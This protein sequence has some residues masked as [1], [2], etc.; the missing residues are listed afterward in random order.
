MNLHLLDGSGFMHRAFHAWPKLSRKD[1]QPCGA[2]LGFCELLWGML[3]RPKHE[4]THLAAIMDGGHSGR[5]KLYKDYKAHRPARDPAL[6]AQYPFIDRACVAF[7]VPVLR[8][9]GFEADDVIATLSAQCT[10]AGGRT[11]IHTADKDLMQ[12]VDERVSIY[13]PTKKLDIGRDQVIA[14]W[15]VPPE[16]VMHVQALLGDAVDG[17]P[18]VPTIGIKGAIELIQRFGDLDTM[19]SRKHEIA[20]PARRSAILGEFEADARLS[21]E[22][23]TLKRDVPLTLALDD[24]VTR[25]RDYRP[26]FEF[27]AEMEFEQL[28]ERISAEAA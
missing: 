27:C 25:V 17:I 18:G 3:A 7:D 11:V 8:V 19:Y 14:K 13:D 24:L 16:R 1:G 4:R 23:A 6:I 10:A 2:V 28:A 20:K 9:P 22:L 12:L 21:L 15:G 5:D 26:I